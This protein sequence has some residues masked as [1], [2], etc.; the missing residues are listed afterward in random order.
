MSVN[1]DHY[2]LSFILSLQSVDESN[3]QVFVLNHLSDILGLLAEADSYSSTAN[4][5]LLSVQ[6]VEA[7][8]LLFEGSVNKNK[9]VVLFISAFLF[10]NVDKSQFWLYKKESCPL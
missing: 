1:V 4:D 10:L 2:I 9:L 5:V 6:S 7:L 8:G 3:Q